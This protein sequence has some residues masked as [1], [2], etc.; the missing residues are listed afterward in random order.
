MPPGAFPGY[1]IPGGEH[2]FGWGGMFGG[3][4][5]V[6]VDGKLA[7][8]SMGE[9]EKIELV[10]QKLAD[11]SFPPFSFVLFLYVI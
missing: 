9:E 4:P 7:E 3:R 5:E 10:M 6:R 2:A 11:V 8:G 1:D